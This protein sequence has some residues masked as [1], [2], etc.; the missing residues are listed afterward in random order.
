MSLLP[1]TLA[2][3]QSQRKTRDVLSFLRTSVYSTESLLGQVMRIKHRSTVHNALVRLEQ[4]GLIRRV[5]IRT[6]MAF[7]T[8]WGITSEGQQLATPSGEEVSPL[9]FNISK[10]SVS[11]L[12]HYLSL[13]QIRITGE[14]VGWTEFVYC[15]REA[16]ANPDK[17][18]SKYNV[19]P[20]LTALDPDS[21][22]VAIECEL[23]LKSPARY[24]ENIIPGHIRHINAE[25]YDY[26]LWITKTPE[27]Q[28][29]LHQ[30]LTARI[31]ELRE[32]ERLH[33]T[34]TFVDYKMFQFANL[35][36]WLK[37]QLVLVS[38]GGQH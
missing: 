7:V 25:E 37:P 13:Q 17:A 22:R 30:S 28:Q 15:D 1:R 20:D 24:K 23:S 9:T 6:A 29:T 35:D 19:R 26:V 34:R 16:R 36:T 21:R 8:L 38:N 3:E 18:E 14:T 4:A 27:D 10:V 11:R 12:E 32:I 2:Y 31:Q 5:P 33:L